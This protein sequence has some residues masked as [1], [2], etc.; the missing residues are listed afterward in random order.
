MQRRTHGGIALREF[1][2]RKKGWKRCAG[3]IFASGAIA[4]N[5]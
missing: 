4:G 3:M 5:F 2:E 1:E